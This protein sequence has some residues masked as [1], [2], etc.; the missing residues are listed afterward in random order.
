MWKGNEFQ[1]KINNSIYFVEANSYE[2]ISLWR[3][4]KERYDENDWKFDNNGYVLSIGN[5]SNHKNKPVCVE[6]FFSE[7]F[8]QQICLYSPTSRFVDYDMIKNWL[9]NYFFNNDGNKLLMTDSMNFHNVIHK[10]IELNNKQKDEN[11][12]KLFTNKV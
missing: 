4:F 6:F 7:L 10:C 3:E 1:N 5:I 2:R 9:K 12:K 11:V 8:G